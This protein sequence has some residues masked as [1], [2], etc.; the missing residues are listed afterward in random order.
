M[1]YKYELIIAPGELVSN[2][3]AIRLGNFVEVAIF[4]HYLLVTGAPFK[5]GGDQT[6]VDYF[7][8]GG[9]Q[10][11]VKLMV[12]RHA[13]YIDEKELRADARIKDALGI[14]D[15]ST[16]EGRFVPPRMLAA[17]TDRIEDKNRNEYYEI[18]PNSD[19]GESAG[20]L[21]LKKIVAGNIRY[22][23]RTVYKPGTLYPSASPT[24][25]P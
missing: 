6:L 19:S 12:Q 7:D 20:V 25:I 2:A 14:P 22:G 23:L 16:Y 18:K 3:G 17:G 24:Y 4:S 5:P 9:P 1:G 8:T 15:I 10:D 21:K 11:Y 13:P